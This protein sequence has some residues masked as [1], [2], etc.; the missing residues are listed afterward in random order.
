MPRNQAELS[1]AAAIVRMPRYDF[2]VQ[3]AYSVADLACYA[4]MDLEEGD[5]ENPKI[6][7]T[8]GVTAISVSFRC[9]KNYS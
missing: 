9:C 3:L 6:D 8:F 4:T 1:I 2:G 7:K 5:D